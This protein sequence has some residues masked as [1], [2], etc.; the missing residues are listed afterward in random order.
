[1]VYKPSQTKTPSSRPVDLDRAEVEQLALLER[2]VN[3]LHRLCT[4]QIA[5]PENEKIIKRHSPVSAFDPLGVKC[6]PLERFRFTGR[7][8]RS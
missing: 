6:N 2:P 8:I 3:T 7:I 1:M 4:R 5:T